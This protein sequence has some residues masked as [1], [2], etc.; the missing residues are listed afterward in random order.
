MKSMGDYN[1]DRFSGGKSFGRQMLHKTICSKCNKECEVPFRPTGSRPVFCKDCFQSNRS[2]NDYPRR[3][4]FENR[5]NAQVGKF[6]EKPQ[7]KE[8]FERL[9]MKLDKILRILEPKIEAN[10][11]SV[12]A[13]KAPKVKKIVKNPTPVKKK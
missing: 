1:K 12:E 4:N 2:S 13:P 9:N 10:A 8:Q 6:V 5:D 3:P 11:L 7:F